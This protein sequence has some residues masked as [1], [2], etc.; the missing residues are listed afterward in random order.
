MDPNLSQALHLINGNTV[1]S[2][3]RDG[4]LLKKQLD[5]GVEPI[6]IAK[7]LYVRC[8]ARQP[9]EQEL[10]DITEFLASA[11]EPLPALEDVFWALLNSQEFIFNH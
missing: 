9:S 2:K 11:G 4:G 10:K 7:D 3:I 5:A 1:Q 8:L 6:E